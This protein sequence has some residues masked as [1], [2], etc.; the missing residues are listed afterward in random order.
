M[1]H[2]TPCPRSPG[3]QPG[4]WPRAPR[5]RRE[6]ATLGTLLGDSL[7]L[8]GFNRALHERVRPLATPVS[9]I[10]PVVIPS[11]GSVRDQFNLV[12]LV[13]M[14]LARVGI[15]VVVHGT[16]QEQASDSSARLSCPRPNSVLWC[17]ATSRGACRSA[18]N[19]NEERK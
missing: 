7:E 3:P 12:P 9:D 16:G 13:A 17:A 4:N 2:C 14:L 18:G 15:P 11:Y 8:L 19:R 1:P 6:Y 10:R 5:A